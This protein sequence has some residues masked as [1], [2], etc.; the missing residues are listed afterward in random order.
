MARFRFSAGLMPGFAVIETTGRRSGLPRQTPV[1]GRMKGSVYWLVAGNSRSQY[2]RNI[3]ADPH[4]RV[5]VHGKWH[6]GT[7]L[8]CHDDNP[9]R[10]LFR[11][12]PVNS[13]FIW[14]AGKDLL[15]VRVDLSD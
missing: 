12:N 14:L 3:E 8:I 4:V 6:S 1:G 7:A 2:I 11:L 13:F 15:T 9:R 5:R 10:R